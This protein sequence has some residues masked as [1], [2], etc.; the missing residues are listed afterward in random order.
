MIQ[1]LCLS[2]CFAWLFP[3]LIGQ[4][5]DQG[6]SGA[7]YTMLIVAAA[8]FIVPF[9]LGSTLAKGLKMPTYGLRF[10][11]ILFALVASGRADRRLIETYTTERSQHTRYI[12]DTDLRLGDV[13]QTT[14]PE[15]AR[16]RDQ[17]AIDAGGAVPLT[18][19]RFPIGP[20]V[21]TGSGL[22]APGRAPTAEEAVWP[23]CFHLIGDVEPSDWAQ[24]A[25]EAL[26]V[27][28]V[29]EPDAAL[30]KWLAAQGDGARAVLVRP[31]T[32]ISG[33]VDTPEQ[34]DTL[35]AE[36]SGW[37]AFEGGPTSEGATSEGAAPGDAA[38]GDG[39][40]A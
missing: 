3:T 19:P 32:L 22:P 21:H 40:A 2:T 14:D 13:I 1:A 10:G 35:L 39:G 33:L 15:V 25:L 7:Q 12:I 30:A 9:I 20:G 5:P 18:P 16:A 28:R 24:T 8:T 27:R 29:P 17:Q 36:W 38:P 31:D 4:T 37:F 23:H 11:F 26:G 34:L 6:I